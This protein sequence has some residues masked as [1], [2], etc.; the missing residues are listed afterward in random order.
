MKRSLCLSFSNQ[1]ELLYEELKL[2]L[3]NTDLP[4]LSRRLVVVYGPAMKSWMMMRMAQDKDLGIAAGIEFLTLSQAFNELLRLACK[5]AP[6]SIPSCRELGLAIEW[7]LLSTIKEYFLLEDSKNPIWQPLIS[8]LGVTNEAP[9]SRKTKKRLTLLS[10]KLAELFQKYGRFSAKEVSLLKCSKEQEWQLLLWKRLFE[11]YPDWTPP[12]IAF[13]QEHKKESSLNTTEA[14]SIHFF[15]ISFLTEAEFSFIER[16][17]EIYPTHYYL[18]SPS[19]L[20]WSDIR[21]DS[22]RFYIRKLLQKKRSSFDSIQELDLLLRERNPLLANF[23]KVGREMAKRIEEGKVITN[24]YYHLCQ[25]ALEM[26]P[27]ADSIEG[28]FLSPP[29]SPQTLLSAL[30]S[31]L[32]LMRQQEDMQA[33]NIP[34]EDF[35]IQL[36]AAPTPKRE[37]EALYHALLHL[38]SINLSLTPADVIVMTP[39]MGRYLPHIHAVF[40]SDESLFDYQV[41][42]VGLDGKRSL[43]TAFLSLL[44]LAESRWSKE[45]VLKLLE[46]PDFKR[47]QGWSNKEAEQIKRW[48]K[49]IAA[50]FGKDSA[51]RNELLKRSGCQDSFVDEKDE[52][53]TWKKEFE[54]L[55]K[56]FILSSS[57]SAFDFSSSELA[58]SLMKVLHSLYHLLQPLSQDEDRSAKEWT[59]YCLLLLD[60]F[61]LPD[62]NSLA[63]N[64]EYSFIQLVL[65]EVAAATKKFPEALFSFGSIKTEIL[66]L[67]DK[68][69][70]AFREDKFQAIRFCS[71]IPLR[72]IPSKVIVISGV[73]EEHFPRAH[74]P[75]SLD[76]LKS[77]ETS[78]KEPSSNEYD[79]Y[80]LL[81]TLHS[82]REALLFTYSYFSEE[83]RKQLRP[84][85]LVEELFG[86]LEKSYT[87]KGKSV[88]ENSFYHHPLDAFNAAYFS[89]NSR[90]KNYSK[91]NFQI[92]KCLQSR[93]KESPHS[94]SSNFSIKKP[95]VQQSEKILLKELRQVARHPIKYYLNKSKNIYLEEAEKRLESKESAK[96]L[97]A[98]D[99]YLF[100]DAVLKESS[101]SFLKEAEEK[102]RLS[103]GMFKT[104]TGIELALEEKKLQDLPTHFG[105][106]FSDFF[107]IEFVLGIKEPLKKERKWL[108]PALE[109]EGLVLTGKIKNATPLGLFLPEKQTLKSAW[110]AW[111][112][113]LLY[114]HAASLS[115]GALKPALILAESQAIKES[116]FEGPIPYLKRYFDYRSHCLQN[117]SPLMPDWIQSIYQKNRGTLKQKI[118]AHYKADQSEYQDKE[119]SW[120]FHENCLPPAETIIEEWSPYLEGL[121]G[122]M[123]VNWFPKLCQR[124]G[125]DESI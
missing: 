125:E 16:L 46:E 32:L 14:L 3:F 56:G 61:F 94:F 24:A 105:L 28:L 112:E 22:E 64:E 12:Y 108:F 62:F 53:G 96:S 119:L 68:P 9:L 63:S 54:R 21:S 113:F 29:D 23:G 70:I 49:E 82:A 44:D 25:S 120:I 114:T 90:L 115:Q 123:I 124:V 7:E 84:S 88:S 50:I 83:D 38:F 74:I 37:M 100:K 60:T 106:D 39:Q 95:S 85:L 107:E 99:K 101:S 76:L 42:D 121:A 33:F 102:G 110:K 109:L 40:G 111:P 30:Q 97:S 18:L 47:K 73:D 55:I 66:S 5:E 79:R 6:P 91:K 36:H 81:E 77:E 116:F 104:L 4:P 122:E 13:K 41:L 26:N 45:S 72:S 35:S 78:D 89:P 87:V 34:E 80:L 57:K 17:G 92:A 43:V 59:D 19:A 20:F 75:S 2:R 118:E 71:L 51:H 11:R 67:I 48:M 31:D 98:L 10:R 103:F 65:K 8:Y 1:L 117:L 93:E 69:S 27:D 52:T 58:G 86:Y 15:S